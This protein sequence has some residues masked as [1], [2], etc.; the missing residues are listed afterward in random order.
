MGNIHGTYCVGI[1]GGVGCGKSA[2]LDHLARKTDCKIIISDDEAKKLYAQGSPIFGKIIEA[3]G[4]DVRDRDGE[5]D[6]KKLAE[7]LFARPDLLEKINSIVHP[8]VMELIDKTISE[9]RKNGRHEF[10]FVEAALLIECGYGDKLDEL[11]YVY[12]SED[13]R[14]R[15]LKENRGY[16]DEKITGMMGS[17]LS[18]AEFRAHCV[19]VIDNNGSME[20]MQRSADNVLETVRSS[21]RTEKGKKRE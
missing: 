11:W 4:E 20:D 12:A 21:I 1:T 5:L 15:R 10:L 7:R 8:A 14:R 16:S 3:A 6:R 17:Q 2:V 19:R 13:V 9:A 18:E